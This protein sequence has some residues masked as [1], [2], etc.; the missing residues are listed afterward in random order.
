VGTLQPLLYAGIHDEGTETDVQVGDIAV[1]GS[2]YRHLVTDFEQLLC[3]WGWRSAISSNCLLD[4]DCYAT[5]KGIH[6]RLS[7]V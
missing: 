1:A 2:S 6:P 7:P 5:K 4:R 3:I